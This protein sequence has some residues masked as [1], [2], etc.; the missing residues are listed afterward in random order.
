MPLKDGSLKSLVV[1]RVDLRHPD[2]Q[3]AL[4]IEHVGEQVFRQMLQTLRY[5]TAIHDLIHRNIK[6]ENILF[7]MKRDTTGQLAYHFTL[8]DFATK[9]DA[10]RIRKNGN[11]A[12]KAPET[13]LSWP[14][15]TSKVDIWSLFATLVWLYDSTGFRDDLG[16]ISAGVSGLT[17]HH[18][19]TDVAETNSRYQ[20][21]RKMA[22]WDPDD[23]PSAEQ[24]LASK[25]YEATEGEHV[26][27]PTDD[28]PYEVN[29]RMET[30]RMCE[31]TMRK[32]SR[33]G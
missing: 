24:L 14:N 17:I 27:A 28:R 2:Q 7:D 10:M 12:F 3:V 32:Y 20:R 5:I 1:N 23:R 11:E 25:A 33:V 6:P 31:S 21:V 13:L 18:W 4:E 15:T 22:R 29:L 30:I 8:A 9:E 26:A 19:L 16:G